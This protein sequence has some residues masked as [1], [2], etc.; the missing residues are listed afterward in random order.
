M[1]EIADL[2]FEQAFQQL[3]EVVRQL[4]SGELPLEQSLALFERGMALAKLC[5]NKLDEA[6]QKVHQ[7][8][9]AGSEG[10]TLT[11]FNAEE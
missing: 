11:P 5:E 4:E 8:V 7:L 3:E 2:T 6:E 10:P 9:G 1:E